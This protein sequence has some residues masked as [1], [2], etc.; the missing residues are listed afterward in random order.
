MKTLI[1]TDL[2]LNSRISGLLDAQLKCISGIY[3]KE[4]PDDV[5]IMGDVFMY[6]KPSPKELL[7]F[8]AILDSM[9]S[10][11]NIYVIR[12][13][14]DSETKADDGITAL[15]LFEDEGVKII[16][17]T[18]IDNKNRRVFIPHYED[19]KTIITALEMV[20]SDYTVFGHF[21][22]IGCLNSA[23]DA[24]FSLTLS[25]FNSTTYLGHIH[26]FCERLGGL[27][28][29]Y[30]KVVCLGTP[31]TTNYGECFKDSF[32]AI[33]DDKLP[34]NVEYKLVESGPRHIMY[35]VHEVENNLDFINDPNYFTF[36]RILV[37]SDHCSIPYNKLKVKYVD[38]KYSPVFNEDDI[39]SYN[40]DRDL[41][42]I[43]DVI[44]ADY[45]EAAN[46][47]ISTDILM[48]GY[49]LLKDEN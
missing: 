14:H 45:V 5:I 31:Y 6:R 3:L 39:S 37:D 23:G 2:H 29:P 12:G 19:E 42:S 17:H 1:V 27:C 34:N 21:G 9:S 30:S 13:N 36:L 38:I 26:S 43:N 24:D 33:L 25:N 47:I 48:E 44:I 11:K 49:R 15:S 7:T 20:P 8:K 10:S 41:F 32:Y 35:S 40:P 46:S 18:Y 4:N 16:E 22:Y 28:K